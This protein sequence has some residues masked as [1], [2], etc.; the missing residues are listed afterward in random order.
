MDG[1]DG[2]PGTQ[3]IEQL[4][5]RAG[6]SVPVI[7]DGALWGALG[8]SSLTGPLPVGTEDRLA[9]FVEIVAAAAASAEARESARVLADEQAA[10]LRVAA[11]VAQGAGEAEIFDAVAVEAAGL[12]DDEPTTLVRYEGEPHVHGARHPPR[13]GPGRH[14][15]HGARPTT[16]APSS[17]MLRTLKPARLDRYDAIADQSYSNRDFGVGS[18]VSVPIIVNG[19]L[20]G[21]LGTLNEGRRLPAETEERLASSPSWSPRPWPTSRPAPSS[22]VSA[23]SRPPCAGSRSSSRARRRRRTILR[24]V[25]AEACALFDGVT[26][27]VWQ[28]GPADTWTSLEVGGSPTDPSATV[29]RSVEDVIARRV[30][31]SGR[32]ARI[33]SLAE[34]SG[35]G[36]P[37]R[38]E[39]RTW[40]VLVAVGPHRS[41]RLRRRTGSC[42]SRRSPPPP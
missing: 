14:E 33:D 42:S 22:S 11:L 30:L 8:V 4:G 13:A 35:A 23:T 40:A 7:V 5:I 6:V 20:W 2:V 24:A 37:V 31:D 32:P 27:T 25:V 1:Y 15:V 19:R 10:L 41:S 16:P 36:A 26:V 29:R 21:S 34:L 38:V 28:H 18:S 39:G 3:L 17:Q 9:V 12:I